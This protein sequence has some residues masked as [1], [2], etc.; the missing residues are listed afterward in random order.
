MHPKLQSVANPF[1]SLSLSPVFHETTLLLPSLE[2]NS[3]FLRHQ[4]PFPLKPK[5]SSTPCSPISLQ[6]FQSLAVAKSHLSAMPVLQIRS[7]LFLLLISALALE[8]SVSETPSAYE[9]LEKFDFPKGI[10]PE[11]VKSY[12]LNG[13]GGFEVYLSGNCEFKVEGGYILK[14]DRKITGKVKSGSLTDLKGVSVK[15]LFAWFGINEVVRN[16][17]D[18]SFYVGPLSASFPV[19]NFDECPRCS[20]GFDCATALPMVS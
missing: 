6:E 10:L 11:G 15:V 8:A 4:N 5:L 12:I 1:V 9:M 3:S 17:S 20:C 13:D 2:I 19:S 16:D 7:C 18:I 14:Y